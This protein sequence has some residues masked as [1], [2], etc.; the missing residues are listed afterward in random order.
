[1]EHIADISIAKRMDEN[2][3]KLDRAIE[4]AHQELDGDPDMVNNPPH[5]HIAGTEVVHILEEMGPHYNGTE[6]FHIL[7]A[8][9]YLLRAH[10]KNGWQDIEKAH[11]HLS[12]AVTVEVLSD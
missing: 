11:W 12:R 10:K 9:Q 1:M 4:K 8:V 5:Y 2:R 3:R 6:G 7:T